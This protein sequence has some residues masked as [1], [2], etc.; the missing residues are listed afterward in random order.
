M[1]ITFLDIVKWY[2][3]KSP[4]MNVDELSKKVHQQLSIIEAVKNDKDKAA[5]E[6]AKTFLMSCK[7]CTKGLLEG[8]FALI[9]IGLMLFLVRG[10]I[11]TE[12][13]IEKAIKELIIEEGFDQFKNIS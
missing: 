4:N 5:Y 7:L 6:I 11:I 3:Q 2:E 9:E 10:T 13:D 8:P 12:E 1:N